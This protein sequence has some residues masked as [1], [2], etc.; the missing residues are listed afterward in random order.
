M[1]GRKTDLESMPKLSSL[2]RYCAWPSPAARAARTKEAVRMMLRR[3]FCFTIGEG[4]G[5]Y[6]VYSVLR[7]LEFE[8]ADPMGKAESRRRRALSKSD[9]VDVG[10]RTL[11]R[12][13]GVGRRATGVGGVAGKHG[14]QVLQQLQIGVQPVAQGVK[15]IDAA[16]EKVN[17]QKVTN[18]SLMVERKLTK[19]LLS[20]ELVSKS[21]A[22]G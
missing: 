5:K 2:M 20:T 3:Y 11:C 1:R 14:Q 16:I 19:T 6:K 7:N 18:S 9:E 12:L 13:S 17:Y 10:E 22:C 15:W 8:F 4:R 21:G